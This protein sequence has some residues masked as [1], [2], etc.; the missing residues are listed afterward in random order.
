LF[1]T[2][3][4]LKV[5]SH[6]LLNS[7][8]YWSEWSASSFRRFSPGERFQCPDLIG[9]PRSVFLQH[10]ARW[11]FSHSYFVTDGRSVGR[12]VGQ[13]VSQSVR[14][15]VLAL[16]PTGTYNQILALIKTTAVL[17]VKGRPRCQKAGFIM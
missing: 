14:P 12:S 9:E 11:S 2:G 16:G 6:A 8:L 3:S 10:S 13:S 1:L 4:Y 7:A 5:K 15:S 17:F